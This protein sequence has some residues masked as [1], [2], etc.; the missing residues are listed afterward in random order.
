MDALTIR[1]FAEKK[2]VSRQAIHE[3]IKRGEID[4][5]EVSNITF[6]DY[7]LKNSKWKPS[8]VHIENGKKRVKK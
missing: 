2:G 3:A 5:C 1:E 7:T 8:K 6:V 4:T